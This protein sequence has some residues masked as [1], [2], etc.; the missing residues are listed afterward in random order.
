MWSIL[1]HIWSLL[2]VVRSRFYQFKIY[3]ICGI[4]NPSP[5]PGALFVQWSRF[6]DFR[7]CT[8]NDIGVLMQ[9]ILWE[10]LLK[11]L[12][13]L[14]QLFKSFFKR[15]GPLSND[16]ITLYVGLHRV[17]SLIEIKSKMWSERRN[18]WSCIRTRI[19]LQL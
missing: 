15:C 6:Q 11:I 14:W 7:I 8:N 2:L 16:L 12:D 9:M 10:R 13:L 4:L 5:T 17:S 1:H 18:G 19:T 3:S